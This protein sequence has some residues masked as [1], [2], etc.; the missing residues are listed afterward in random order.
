MEQQPQ[1]QWSKNTAVLHQNTEQELLVLRQLGV[2]LPQQQVWFPYSIESVQAVT[3]FRLG[4]EI[5]SSKQKEEKAAQA[6][7]YV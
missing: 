5:S 3:A 6:A 1:Q 2:A 4:L 7:Q